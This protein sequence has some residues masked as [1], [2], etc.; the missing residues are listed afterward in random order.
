MSLVLVSHHL[1]FVRNCGFF[2]GIKWLVTGDWGAAFH[3][4]ELI[5]AD[6]ATTEK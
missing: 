1:D 3:Q 6:E 4:R 5:R 2:C